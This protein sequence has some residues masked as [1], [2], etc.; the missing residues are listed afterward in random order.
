MDYVI[1]TNTIVHYLSKQSNVL[2]NFDDA[3]IRNCNLIIPKAVDYELRRGFSIYHAPKK[4]AAY[5]ILIQQCTMGELNFN[6]WDCAVHIYTE[7]YKKRLTVGDIDILIAAFCLV[8][9]YILVTNNTRDFDNIKG[10]K[11]VDWAQMQ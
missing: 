11:L 10:I 3:A 1:D 6:V 8:N 7:L 4:E 5:N 2:R 9:D